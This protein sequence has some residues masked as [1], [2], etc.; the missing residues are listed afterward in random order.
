MATL[1]YVYIAGSLRARAMKIGVTNNPA[2]RQTDHRRNRHGGF[3]DWQVLY[4]ARSYDA[5]RTEMDVL[6]GLYNY[7]RLTESGA[8]E[9]VRCS[10]AQAHDVLSGLI[11]ERARSEAWWSE[12]CFKYEFNHLPRTAIQVEAEAERRVAY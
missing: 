6:G 5:F 7:E 4:Y 9:I 2:R 12:S 11:T 1:S 10:F 8:Q 3:G